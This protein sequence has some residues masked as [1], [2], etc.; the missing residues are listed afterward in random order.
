[1]IGKA[2]MANIGGPR[3][4]PKTYQRRPAE[5]TKHAFTTLNCDLELLDDAANPN[6]SRI[7]AMPEEIE[8]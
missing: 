1:V 3:S 6:V 5:T 4:K 8:T 7:L 2:L